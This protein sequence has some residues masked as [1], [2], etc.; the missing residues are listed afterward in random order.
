VGYLG[1]LEKGFVAVGVYYCSSANQFGHFEFGIVD[2]LVDPVGRTWR[3]VSTEFV[4]WM[5][6]M[7]EA[8][9]QKP[10]VSHQDLG[11]AILKFYRVRDRLEREIASAGGLNGDQHSPGVGVEG[12]G[13]TKMRTVASDES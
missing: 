11:A 5:A 9:F 1:Y 4:L 3:L 6:S 10:S 7:V 2:P 8:A 12:S 13:N